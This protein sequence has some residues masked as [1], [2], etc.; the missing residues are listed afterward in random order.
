MFTLATSSEQREGNHH[1]S[2]SDQEQ[3]THR[4]RRGE[5]VR[6]GQPD[7]HPAGLCWSCDVEERASIESRVAVASQNLPRSSSL[8]V[9]VVFLPRRSRRCRRSW[10][11]RRDW[12]ASRRT[13]C[14]RTGACASRSRRR[15]VSA[16]RTKSRRSQKSRSQAPAPQLSVGCACKIQKKRQTPVKFSVQIDAMH[17]CSYST[18]QAAQDTG[19]AVRQHT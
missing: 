14:W 17:L 5:E 19:P 8:E 9:I 18:S 7:P 16:T 4:H 2:I 1:G 12:R 3:T 13:P 6:E 11:S 10:R 15:G